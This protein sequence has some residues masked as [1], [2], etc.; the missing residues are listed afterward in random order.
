MARKPLRLRNDPPY[1]GESLSSFLGRTALFYGTP[2]GALMEQLMDGHDW[3]AKGRPDLDLNPPDV[4][5][6]RLAESVEGWRSPVDEHQGFHGWVLAP[7]RRNAYCPLCFYQD[8]AKGRTPYFRMDWM[9]VFVSTCWEHGTPLMEWQELDCHG[10]CRLPKCWLFRSR[11]EKVTW[12]L[13]FSE[14]CRRLMRIAAPEH[15]EK[16]PVPGEVFAYLYGLQVAVEK[17]SAE[18]MDT[19]P[20][21]QSPSDAVRSM[22]K[23]L[24]L[25]LVSEGIPPEVVGTRNSWLSSSTGSGSVPFY[26]IYSPALR[27]RWRPTLVDAIRQTS[28]LEMRRAY[29]YFAAKVLAD[30]EDFGQA[31]TVNRP[32]KRPWEAWR[33]D[34]VWR[35]VLANQECDFRFWCPRLT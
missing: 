11:R 6:S 1:Q 18:R 32:A 10:R 26:G 4:L 34:D 16:E 3:D 23:E 14:H 20:M 5:Q 29:L 19:Y 22:A 8:L 9:A 24:V 33:W 15:G 25:S 30:S 31:I 35:A 12:P 28:M 7:K 2:F 13:N 21:A 27:Q 17:R